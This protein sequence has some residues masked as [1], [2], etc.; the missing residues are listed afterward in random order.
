METPHDQTLEFE[1]TESLHDTLAKCET[2]QDLWLWC[3]YCERFFQARH[4]KIDYLGNREGCAFCTCAGF[5]CAIFKW[6]T[7]REPHD[8]SWPVSESVLSH[9]LRLMNPPAQ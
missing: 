2:P 6:D 8:S 3:I 1:I 4:L 5:D 9:G 7:F